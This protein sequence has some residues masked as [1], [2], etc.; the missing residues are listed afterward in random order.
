MPENELDSLLLQKAVEPLSSQAIQELQRIASLNVIDFKEADV[1][2]EIINPILKIIGYQKGNE[3][4]VDR[5]KHIKFVGAKNKYIDYSLTVWE[6]DF[7]LIEAKRPN[8]RKQSFCYK[9]ASQAFEYASH[10]DIRAALVVLCDGIKLELFDREINV[11]QPA[12]RVEIKNI[13]EEY[14]ELAKYLSPINVWLFYRRRLLRELDRAFEKEGNLNRVSEYKEIMS[15]HLDGM[16]SRVLDNFRNNDKKG[17]GKN[18]GLLAKADTRDITECHFF[19]A[20]SHAAIS[21]MSQLLLKECKEKSAFHTFHRIFPDEPRD[22]NDFFYMH[23]TDFAIQLEASDVAINWAPSWLGGSQCR[24]N[25]QL[26]VDRLI[27]S[28]LSHFE[29]DSSRKIISLASS[30]YRRILKILAIAT[31]G[32]RKSA[33]VLHLLTRLSE[34]EHTWGQI[35]SSAERN[36]IFH[37]ENSSIS[38]TNR[39]V[40]RFSNGPKGFK[41]HLAKQEL[42]R[43]YQAEIEILEK[44]PAY[45]ELAREADIG[46][47]HPTEQCCISYDHL[48][49]GVLCIVAQYERWGSYVLDK[50]H[51]EIVELAQLGSWSARQLLGENIE[52]RGKSKYTYD[53]SV[54]SKRF[55]FGDEN[56]CESLL[57]AYNK[58]I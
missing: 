18:I 13:S 11:E 4:S 46:E 25:R 29:N 58:Q 54:A 24:D 49:H 30:A 51:A 39:F 38:A 12:L 56:L 35:L 23:A 17:S 10:P 27:S 43:M 33:E 21:T 47:V 36:I 9:D 16:R 3:H 48:G 53:L 28:L 7:W 19:V 5:E 14:P 1:R 37:L 32:P 22:A 6:Q 40:S 31:P 34:P 20:K 50:H 44:F 41:T 26:I 57:N 8:P 42:L 52:G 45:N 55:F 2:E 15:R